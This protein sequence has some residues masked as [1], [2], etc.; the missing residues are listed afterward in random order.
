VK[1]ARAPGKVML[2]GEYA[3]LEGA[4]ALV[5]AVDRHARV[6]TVGADDTVSVLPRET[7]AALEEAHAGGLLRNPRPMFA[8]DVSALNDG[9]NKLGLGSSAAAAVAALGLALHLEGGDVA[10]QREAIARAARRGHRKA[11]G[12]GSGV[13]VIASALGGAVAVT[14]DQDPEREPA[15]ERLA[16]PNGL[17]WAVLWTGTPARTS[18][19][20]AQVR[21]LPSA[22]YKPLMQTLREASEAFLAAFR[23]GEV[24]QL[25]D[26]TLA[27]C[28][29]EAALGKAAGVP[30]VTETMN[31][32]SAMCASRGVA[33]KPSGAGGGDVVLALG[34]TREGL[35]DVVR[36][37]EQ[38][39]FSRLAM[40][41]DAQGVS[42]DVATT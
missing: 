22:T 25:L 18:D 19:M 42:V 31:A 37:A 17:H 2:S 27:H 41:E 33:I 26:A 23:K 15:I 20:L 40:G 4:T 16:M 1:S 3:V 34:S 35:D 38:S 29:A 36:L 39:G 28:E 5:L 21:A 32:L 24:S 7:R 9:P 6:R 13:D 30:I 8:L 10:S 14:L 11:Q 12:G